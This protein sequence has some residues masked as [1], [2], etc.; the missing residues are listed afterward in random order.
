MTDNQAEKGRPRLLPPAPAGFDPFTATAHDLVRHGLPR[1]P[2]PKTEPDLAALW[3]RKAAQYRN[4]EHLAPAAQ[5]SGVVSLVA[6]TGIGPDP[7]DSA[8][9]NLTTGSGPFTS[10]FVTWTIPDLHFDSDAFG[11]NQ[12]HTF[13]GLGFL[14][15]HVSLSVNSSQT[16]TSTLSAVG[17]GDVG[18]TVRPGD[19]ISASLCLNTNAAGTAAYFFTNETTQQTMSFSVDTGF[20]PA[21]TVNAGVTRDGVIR[22]GQSLAGFG[23][24]YFDEISAYN[25]S[26]HQSLLSGQAIN[27]TDST[28]KVLA[29]TYELTDYAFKVVW[30]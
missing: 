22:P 2:D 3:D 29:N 15:V 1:R 16:V 4:F 5:P 11:I 6:P 26:G 25:T 28:G 13:V 21:Q 23:T 20:P 17:V 14:D 24:V 12:L 27:M 30:G 19:V 8:G 7:F 18:L 9:Y 10:L